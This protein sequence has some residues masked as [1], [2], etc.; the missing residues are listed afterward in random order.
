MA[1][2]GIVASLPLFAGMAGDIVGGLYGDRI[3][4]ATGRLNFSRRM[5]AVPGMLGTALFIIP[6]GMV[7]SD[8]IAV[9]CMSISL[10]FMEFLNAPS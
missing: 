6:A 5:V 3:L 2:M 9:I 1:E 8:S 4:A 10:F 7:D